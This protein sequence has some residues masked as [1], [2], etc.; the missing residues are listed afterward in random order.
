M[1]KGVSIALVLLTLAAIFHFSVATHYCRGEAVASKVSLTGKLAN[2]G[3]EGQE[4][5]LPLSGASITSHCCDDVVN[6][7]GTDNNYAPSFS[8]FSDTYQYNFR[9]F[10][11]APGYPVYA[12]AALKPLYANARPPGALMSTNVDLSDICV[13][14][15]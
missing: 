9:I 4:K 11:I 5:E 10:S 1:K 6:Y 14:R 3:M 8:F 7:C 15:I 2:C 13:F 12:P